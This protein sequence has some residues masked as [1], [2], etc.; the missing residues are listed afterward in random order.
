MVFNTMDNSL[1]IIVAGY[2]M[3]N[4]KPPYKL[5]SYPDLSNVSIEELISLDQKEQYRK[6]YHAR[7]TSP[8]TSKVMISGYF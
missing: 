3:V 5:T 7:K 6:E 1:I 2:F 8:A 4:Q